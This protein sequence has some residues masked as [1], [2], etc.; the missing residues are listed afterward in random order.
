[1]SSGGVTDT[2]GSTFSKTASSN[3][4][5]DTEIWCGQYTAATGSDTV[6]V[7]STASATYSFTV[8]ILGGL[9]SCSGATVRT[10]SG[11]NS[12]L[13]VSS[14][15]PATGAA[16]IGIGNEAS[17]A[18]GS[19]T[20]TQPNPFLYE[21]GG[22]APNTS[23]AFAATHWAVTLLR[24]AWNAND[25]STI[26]TITPSGGVSGNSWDEVL[27]CYSTSSAG[28]D[29]YNEGPR[30]GGRGAAN[31]PGEGVNG[32][33][34]GDYI[35][36]F[37]AVGGSVITVSSISDTNGGGDTW[38]KVGGSNI[39]NDIEI[40][41]AQAA[42]TTACCSGF[43][44]N[45][46]LSG[47]PSA[48]FVIG[49]D[50]G[51]ISSTSAEIFTGSGTSSTISLPAFTPNSGDLCLEAVS[52]ISGSGSTTFSVPA[53]QPFQN[54]EPAGP[55]ANLANF[56]FAYAVRANWPAGVSSTGTI[57]MTGTSSPQWDAVVVC[58]PGTVVVPVTCTMDNSAP[59]AT[60]SLSESSGNSLSPSSVVCDGT[61]H[62]I[63]VDPSVTL[64]ATEPA[65]G[66][67]SRDRF[68]GVTTT[69]TDS[70]CAGSSNGKCA[71]FTFTNY[72]QLLNTYQAT[73]NAQTTWDSG[74]TALNVVGQVAGATGTT[75]CSI[76][77]TGG[78]GAS[79]CN[80]WFDYNRAV[81][82]GGSTIGGAPLNTQWLRS[83]TCSFSQTSGSNIDNCNYYKQLLNT[84]TATP[85]T[86][87]DSGLTIVP[88][89]TLLGS[90]GSTICTLSPTGGSSSAASCTAWADYNQPVNF[91]AQPTGCPADHCWV[92]TGT[93]SFTDT[94]GGN[95]HNVNYDRNFPR[96]AS[97]AY[98]FSDSPSRMTLLPRAAGDSF[99]FSETAG[100]LVSLP[101]SP[102]DAFVF[103]E[104]ASTNLIFSRSA[105][106][107]FAFSDAATRGL[108]FGRGATDSFG[109]SDAPARS[110][111]LARS[112]GDSA[113]FSEVSSS[114]SA[115]TRVIGDSYSFLEATLSNAFFARSAGDAFA[116]SDVVTSMLLFSRSISDTFAFAE[117][118]IANVILSRISTDAYV[119]TDIVNRL[120]L[121]GRTVAEAF[122]FS[123]AAASL[124]GLAR[125]V[126]D[127]FSFGD[128]ATRLVALAR[129]VGDAYP[130][131]EIPASILS[132]ARSVGD[133]FGSTESVLRSLALFRPIADVFTFSDLEARLVFLGRLVGDTFAFA[134]LPSRLVAL[135]RSVNDTYTFGDFLGQLKHFF[136]QVHDTFTFGDSVARMV[137]LF[138]SI[139]DTLPFGDS[140]A[141]DL[142]LLRGVAD[143]F[144]VSVSAVV[145]VALSIA[146][147]DVFTF[148]ETALSTVS[149]FVLTT[150]TSGGGFVPAYNSV[151]FFFLPL[152]ILL[153]VLL[154]LLAAYLKRRRR[155]PEDPPTTDG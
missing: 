121:L 19:I 137:A 97:D 124:L 26:A 12:V 74:L 28:N 52:T 145:M 75:G 147:G 107:S 37:T 154:I 85:N 82:I 38:S 55:N 91:P 77:L 128:A 95:S 43:G 2:A 10:N 115:F 90:G 73:P 89:G 72:D 139:T 119:V 9:S 56:Y 125:S 150:T 83:G 152:L 7:K 142:A 22:G 59:Q 71:A 104:S 18:A 54:L 123:D 134:D 64:T 6:T 36:Q 46:L 66:A 105:P 51:S 21:N 4:N 44:V 5:Q 81:T 41:T 133:T 135:L 143:G 100:R 53:N 33:L 65:D 14:F 76:T 67:S 63:S 47:T 151:I 126:A 88:T 130:F 39:H 144:A 102:G 129:L 114:M 30:G 94:T 61:A 110:D 84:Y 20:F 93:T 118:S 49:Y 86:N 16:C 79:S 8:Y 149:T 132:L 112:P 78:G 131:A 80:A 92:A 155:E 57:T 106:D 141:R 45:D 29:A 34:K 103:A 116:F 27:S 24:G 108:V 48:S 122:S 96:S 1:V 120:L 58:F 35:I 101:R 32:V 111:I 68:S 3:V 136:F 148:M 138:R 87:W 69:Q 11:S 15:T 31:N 40:W 70:V 23:P 153:L 109:F 62:N 17:G 50:I 99:S 25:G 127:T 60:L 140:V 117:S 13:S 42:Q 146:I 98:V 113:P